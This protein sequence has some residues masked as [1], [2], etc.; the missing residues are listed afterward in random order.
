MYCC[1]KWEQLQQA[2]INRVLGT[3]VK[4]YLNINAL[5]DIWFTVQVDI[6]LLIR[7]SGTHCM[8]TAIDGQADA[9]RKRCQIAGQKCDRIC[10]LIHGAG[11]S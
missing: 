2:Q 5:T 6:Y 8:T 4:F 9:R 10:H 3:I 11:S 7:L 1:R